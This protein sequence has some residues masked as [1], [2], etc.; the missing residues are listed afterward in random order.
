MRAKKF[1]VGGVVAAALAIGVPV[2]SAAD[3]LTVGK[4]TALAA[5]TRVCQYFVAK[6]SPLLVKDSAGQLQLITAAKGSVANISLVADWNNGKRVAAGNFY[7]RLNGS[8]VRYASPGV[9]EHK[10]LTARR[11]KAGA[12]ICWMQ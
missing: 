11:N 7:H 1:I 4:G 2:A 6:D 3:T 12:H 10:D 8:Y 9:I 5:K